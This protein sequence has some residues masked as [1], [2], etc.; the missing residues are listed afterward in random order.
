VAVAQIV[1][2]HGLAGE[3]TVELYTDFPER[4]AE[5]EGIEVSGPGRARRLRVASLR[6]TSQGRGLIKFD[7]VDNRDEA[8]KLRGCLVRVDRD[9]IPA[10]PEGAYYDF[11]IVGLRV[12]TTAGKQLGQVTEII[13]TGA[14]DVYVTERAL[15]PAV[16][17]VIRE[18]DLE[19]GEIVIE[20]VA[21]LLE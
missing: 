12:V 17:S 2:P 8:E 3:V 19:R 10:P 4:L 6:P 20:E 13:R 15:I 14:N 21:G 7:G 5:A 18:I 9:S 1:K 16:D 11:Q